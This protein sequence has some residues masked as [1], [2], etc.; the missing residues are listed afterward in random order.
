[1]SQWDDA[2][3]AETIGVGAMV[4]GFLSLMLCWWIPFGAILGAW[5]LGFGLAAR[6]AGGSR[7]ALIGSVS[8]A[9]GLAAG[10]LLTL[11]D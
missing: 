10:L 7:S 1:M 8:S 4:F 11:W 2:T 3:R 6:L 5:G 9:S